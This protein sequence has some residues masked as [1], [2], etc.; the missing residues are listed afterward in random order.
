MK[1]FIR[2]QRVDMDG[3][4][5]RELH[6]EPRHNGCIARVLGMETIP[7][8]DD[9]NDEGMSDTAHPEYTVFTVAVVDRTGQETDEI[10]EI[11]DHEIE[12][13]GDRPTFYYKVGSTFVC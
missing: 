10:L 4:C 3:F 11:M 6:P 12:M 5:G 7:Q 13:S 8:E 9:D 1:M 2:I